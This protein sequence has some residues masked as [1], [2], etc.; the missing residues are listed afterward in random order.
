MTSAVLEAIQSLKLKKVTLI[1]PYPEGTG[2]RERDFLERSIP[3]LTVVSMKHLGIIS[4]FEK[5]LIPYST[6]YRLAKAMTTGEMDGLFLSC[7]ALRTM[8]IIGP[9]EKDLGIP[10]VTSTQAGLWA[11]LRRCRVRGSPQF[12]RLFD[13]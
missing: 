10:V 11:C 7:S 5:S 12:G 9:L 6:T 8:E 4:S 13:L 1:S 3:G 2:M